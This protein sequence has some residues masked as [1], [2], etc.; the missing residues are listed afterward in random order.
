MSD[1]STMAAGP[2][3]WTAGEVAGEIAHVPQHL[4]DTFFQD[5][6]SFESVAVAHSPTEASYHWELLSWAEQAN[7]GA[8]VGDPPAHFTTGASVDAVGTAA[9]A[10]PIPVAEPLLTASSFT[11]S[12]VSPSTTS[13]F[14][15]PSGPITEE[16]ITQIV[17][18]VPSHLVD[19]FFQ[20]PGAFIAAADAYDPSRTGYFLDALSW[21]Q[22]ARA[23]LDGPPV[24]TPAAPANDAGIADFV[25]PVGRLTPEQIGAAVAEVVPR[26]VSDSFWQGSFDASLSGYSTAE[27]N[28]FRTVMQWAERAVPWNASMAQLPPDV[29]TR[30]ESGDW[31]GVEQALSVYD[32]TSQ[33]SIQGQ[34]EGMLRRD[35]G[36][37]TVHTFGLDGAARQAVLDGDGA[38]LD[39]ALAGEDST[40][41]DQIAQAVV[42]TAFVAAAVYV[43]AS[44][45]G[46]FLSGDLDA[47]LPQLDAPASAAV[48]RILTQALGVDSLTAPPTPASTVGPATAEPLTRASLDASLDAAGVPLAVRDAFFETPETLH[49]ALAAHPEGNHTQWWGALTAYERGSALLEGAQRLPENVADA[50]LSGDSAA[51]E[52]AIQSLPEE[53]HLGVRQQVAEI[54]AQDQRFAL[55]RSL[56]IGMPD[57]TA[58]PEPV[59]EAFVAGDGFALALALGS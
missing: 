14:V 21:A 42:D 18:Q 44:Q 28:L 30:I 43:P 32:A 34:I 31:P 19:I 26:A 33:A 7:G 9:T 13:G 37:A 15:P 20:D 10:A 38:A 58:M 27:Q 39:A 16:L 17:G 53:Q 6:G 40:R 1:A 22:N 2:R 24:T 51:L 49:L 59:R 5:R 36:L 57:G 12:S 54:V 50:L 25:P 3:V 46:A 48:E 47:V 11:V 29:A 35:L 52:A 55:G 23:T 8:L 4:I 41:R 56:D 45:R